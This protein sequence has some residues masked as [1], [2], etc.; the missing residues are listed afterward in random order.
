MEYL[1]E[2]DNITKKYG[3]LVAVDHVSIRLKQGEIYGLIGRNGAGKTT[4]LKMLAGLAKPTEGS[5]TIFG[6]SE[7]KTARMRDRVGVLI[8]TP[9]L[10]PNLN[11]M[12]NMKIMA[13]ILGE[14]DESYLQELL[15]A[16]GLSG[17]GKRKVKAFSMGMKQRLGIAMSLVG[18]PD[19]LLLDEPINGLD[20]QGIVEV[21]ELISRLNKER[22]ITILISSHILEEL[23]KIVTRY[24]IIHNGRIIDQFSQAEL[25]R[26]CQE[27][28]EIR[29]SDTTK[30]V[31]VIEKMGISDFKVV[32]N[33]VIQIFERLEDSGEIVLELAKNNIKTLNISVKNEN[34]EDYFLAVTGGANVR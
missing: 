14:N 6:E 2:T 24:G 9:G 34:L 8:E 26:R 13:M 22:N 29:P 1:L 27:R 16:V 15:D 20:P 12:A 11:A 32:D 4:L 18:H 25:L 33:S 23:S 31:T 5:F 30:A 10:Y 17:V 19:I 28:I 3:P 21:R 7:E